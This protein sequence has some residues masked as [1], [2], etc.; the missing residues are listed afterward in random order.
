MTILETHIVPENVSGIRLSDYAIGIFTI[1]PTRKGMKKA[2]KKGAVYIDGQLATTGRWVVSG[3]EI[4]LIEL[5]QKPSK[6]YRLDLEVIYEDNEIAIINKPPGIVVSGNQFRTIQNALPNNLSIS[7]ALDAFPCPLPVH[8]LDY[9]TS[10]LLLIAKTQ[11]AR[12]FLGKAFEQHQIQKEYQ[13]VVIGK[14]PKK[15]V[16]QEPV[17]QKKSQTIFK[18]ITTVPSLKNGYLSLVQLIPL[19]GRM[20]QL[21]IHLAGAGFPILGDKLYGTNGMILKGKGLFLCA[22]GLQFAHPETGIQMNFNIPNPPK[23][24]TFMDREKK[25]WEKYH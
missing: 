1:I 6:A 19:T 17:H 7:T 15:G 4:Q 16:I 12:R 3:Q 9:S 2:I 21:R 20:H 24:Q 5:V 11:R 14:P 8:R 13:A 23:F 10:G 22:V 25:R 18:T